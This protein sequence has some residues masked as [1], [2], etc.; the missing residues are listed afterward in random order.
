VSSRHH[1]RIRRLVDW[2]RQHAQ[3]LAPLVAFYGSSSPT[4]LD[5]PPEE[6]EAAQGAGRRVLHVH[7][8]SANAVKNDDPRVTNREGEAVTDCVIGG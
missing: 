8:V 2:M 4:L 5:T 1:D 3:H 6:I 7:F